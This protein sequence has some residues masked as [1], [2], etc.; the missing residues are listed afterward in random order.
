MIV[1]P[2]SQLEPPPPPRQ[3]PTPIPYPIS[4]G[5]TGPHSVPDFSL[6]VLILRCTRND[7]LRTWFPLPP[8]RRLG[9]VQWCKPCWRNKIVLSASRLQHFRS[10]KRAFR[11]SKHNFSKTCSNYSHPPTTPPLKH[12]VFHPFLPKETCF[13]SSQF[14]DGATVNVL[15]V[16]T[17]SQGV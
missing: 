13:F 4:V 17:F 8:G 7:S 3:R 16:F 5:E 9:E 2:T 12:L 6:G 11:G 10:F 14:D 1:L 15:W